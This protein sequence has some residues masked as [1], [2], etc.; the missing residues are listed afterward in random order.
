MSGLDE[1]ITAEDV[2]MRIQLIF[3]SLSSSARQA[4]FR[5]GQSASPAR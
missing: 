4:P 5:H 3:A 2:A 1:I